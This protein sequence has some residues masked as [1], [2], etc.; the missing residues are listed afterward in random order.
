[1]NINQL[2]YFVQTVESKSYARAAES[3]HVSQQAI[4]K[5]IRLL[6]KELGVALLA[7][8]H[9]QIAATKTGATVCLLSQDVLSSVEAV[10]AF[11]LLERTKSSAKPGERVRIAIGLSP[12]RASWFQESEVNEVSTQYAGVETD[13]RRFD[14]GGTCLALL[15]D[16]QVDIAIIAGPVNFSCFSSVF[17]FEV[18]LNVVVGKNSPLAKRKSLSLAEIVKYPIAN[19]S[20]IRYCRNIISDKFRGRGLRPRFTDV[21]FSCHEEINTFL[22]AEHG[23]IFVAAD[24]LLQSPNRTELVACPL[25][26]D[27]QIQVPFYCAWRDEGAD[28]SLRRTVACIQLRTRQLCRRL[29]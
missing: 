20:D 26:N 3:L 23:A 28:E 8:E 18:N 10:E 9:G 25:C 1:M 22:D 19:M 27:D 16:D 21:H 4:S 2:Q 12:L 17:L 13:I 14:D 11:A 5:S 7:K 24:K 29:H 15:Q 6:E